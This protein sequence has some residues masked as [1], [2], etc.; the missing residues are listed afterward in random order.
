MGSAR[1]TSEEGR[2]TNERNK[3]SKERKGKMHMC[4][5]AVSETK[6]SR[7]PPLSYN[8][9]VWCSGTKVGRRVTTLKGSTAWRDDPSEIIGLLCIL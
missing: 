9:G 5:I 8:L 3:A 1:S 7:L 4:E 6:H 2:R